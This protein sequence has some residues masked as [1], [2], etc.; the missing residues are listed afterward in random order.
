MEPQRH[1]GHKEDRGQSENPETRTVPV[2]TLSSCLLCALRAFVINP[3]LHHEVPMRIVSV[4]TLTLAL[5]LSARG[6]EP[7]VVKLWPG[8]APGETKDIGPE[9]E[10][11]SKP[12]QLQIKRLANVSDP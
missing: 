6:A 10:E 11:P 7:V 8:K 3:L 5:T 2:L 9:K 12:G 4:F 1:E